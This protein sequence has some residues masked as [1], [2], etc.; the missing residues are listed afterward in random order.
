MRPDAHLRALAL[1]LGG[2]GAAALIGVMASVQ[3]GD[4]Y[5]QLSRPPWAPPA[6]VS[7]P[8]WS[9]LYVLMAVAAWLG[10]RARRHA[11]AAPTPQARTPSGGP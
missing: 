7:G 3:A 4:F 9:V 5:Q 6:R 1:L 8:A 10:I 11:S 2:T